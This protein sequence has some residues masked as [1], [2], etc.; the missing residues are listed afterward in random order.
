M[1]SKQALGSTQP[2]PLEMPTPAK[3]LHRRLNQT[4][5]VAMHVLP[6]PIRRRLGWW[7]WDELM[8][9]HEYS[10]VLWVH[11]E[12]RPHRLPA[13]KLWRRGLLPSPYKESKK[14]WPRA[15]KTLSGQSRD[16]DEWHKVPDTELAAW[17]E[18]WRAHPQGKECLNK[19]LL[20]LI[21]KGEKDR[22]RMLLVA[23]DEWDEESDL[24]KA[25][26]ESLWRKPRPLQES[27]ALWGMLREVGVHVQSWEEWAEETSD[28]M[29]ACW[30]ARDMERWRQS[31][32]PLPTGEAMLRHALAWVN[33]PALSVR[34][35]G[36]SG[37]SGES[38]DEGDM[39]TAIQAIRWFKEY[40]NLPSDAP[41]RLLQKWLS[42]ARPGAKAHYE[43]AVCLWL[44]ELLSDGLPPRPAAGPRWKYLA[45]TIDD[46]PQPWSHWWA[47]CKFFENI[48][49]D[50][51]EKM[52]DEPDAWTSINQYGEGIRDIVARRI[53]EIRGQHRDIGLKKVQSWILASSMDVVIPGPP[54]PDC[55]QSPITPSRSRL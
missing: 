47:S 4:V 44:D 40:G 45:G 3:G 38:G 15:F 10:N 31:G 34:L 48:P 43:R 18:M 11:G 6:G 9:G 30:T 22:V 17:V 23:Q 51:V 29:P 35:Q 21:D 36:V 16:R 53:K 33:D 14:I 5:L 41:T 1:E 20:G 27:L 19:A 49:L 52:F 54:G 50:Y 55:S 46:G 8:E 37:N 2:S 32:L 12:H 25:L 39:E 28:Q 42:T 13:A 24:P 7:R 26:F